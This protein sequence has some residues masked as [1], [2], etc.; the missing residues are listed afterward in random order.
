MHKLAGTTSLVHDLNVCSS[1]IVS[2][3]WFPRDFPTGEL[4]TSKVGKNLPEK[5]IFVYRICIPKD[6]PLFLTVK[7]APVTLPYLRLSSTFLSTNS[8]QCRK[9]HKRLLLCRHSHSPFN[10]GIIKLRLHST[11]K[12]DL[13]G[14]QATNQVNHPQGVFT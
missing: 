14:C 12:I 9:N 10:S 6:G 2:C 5:Q 13:D 3:L 7:T 1:L 8:C 4:A 11:S